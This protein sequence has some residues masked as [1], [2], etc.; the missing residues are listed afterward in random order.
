ML[1]T[2]AKM[3]DCQLETT[4]K[5]KFLVTITNTSPTATANNV[6]AT[7]SL[8]GSAK[9]IE[10]TPKQVNFGAIGPKCKV[11]KEL[12]ICT[13]NAVPNRYRVQLPLKYGCE[14]PKQECEQQYFNVV[15]D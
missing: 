2:S 4:D 11:T 12:E 1:T 8:H 15:K 10:L 9:G 14:T 3:T 7:P 13:V 5:T 6:V